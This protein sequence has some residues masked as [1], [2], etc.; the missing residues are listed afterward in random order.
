MNHEKITDE[1]FRLH[2]MRREDNRLLDEAQSWIQT[3]EQEQDMGTQLIAE[4]AGFDGSSIS[5][6]TLC[7]E[8]A[9]LLKR[10]NV[11]QRRS[12]LLLFRDE[13]KVSKDK[14][15]QIMRYK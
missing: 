10:E 12:E 6:G 7:L 3:R 15:K 2:A 8:G 14:L 9:I 4:C 5:L 11:V 13:R 1:F